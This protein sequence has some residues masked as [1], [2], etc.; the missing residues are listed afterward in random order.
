MNNITGLN[1]VHVL[2]EAVVVGGISL[3]FHNR[4]TQLE[5]EVANLK[6][7][8]ETQTR[9]IMFLSGI[10]GPSDGGDITGALKTRIC[11]GDVCGIRPPSQPVEKKVV[12]SKVSKQVAYD[13]EGVMSSPEKIPTFTKPSPNPV[14]KSVTPNSSCDV[15]SASSPRVDDSLDFIL[16]DIDNE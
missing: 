14:L 7:V 10:R 8:V 12:I 9:Q 3:Y 4:L 11:A 15:P 6:T 13:D 1:S 5:S 16:A 2:S